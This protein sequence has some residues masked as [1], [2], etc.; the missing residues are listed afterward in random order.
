MESLADNLLEREIARLSPSHLK[1]LSFPAALEAQFETDTAFER[2]H[3]FWLEG[4]IAIIALNLCLLL[5]LLI[6][7]QGRW[8]DVILHTIVVTPLALLVNSIMRADPPKW[9]RE[10]SVA[11][12]TGLIGLISMRAEGSTTP[13]ATIFGLVCVLLMILFAD[14]VMR[15][16]FAYAA[17]VTGALF[18]GGLIF[19]GQALGESSRQQPLGCRS[20]HHRDGRL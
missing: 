1:K 10:G 6:L 5:D 15:L 4:L 2:S 18:A 20:C 17:S 12:G 14:V 7:R 19:L 13:A 16:R 11:L 3:R 8:R 9:L